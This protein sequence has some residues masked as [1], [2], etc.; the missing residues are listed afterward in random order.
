MAGVLDDDVTP[1]D[2]RLHRE[3]CPVIKGSGGLIRP[4]WCSAD[5]AGLMRAL[6]VDFAAENYTRHPDLL[7]HTEGALQVFFTP[8]DH[9]PR[10]GKVLLV[11]HTP[12]R[13]QAYLALTTTAEQLRAGASIDIALTEASR[14]GSFA[15]AMRRN[16]AAMFDDLGLHQHLGLS[17]CTEL[18]GERRDLLAGTSAICYPV[19]VNDANYGG[20]NPP[21][22]R[23]P[24]LRAF[25]SQVL[26]AELARIP[27]ALIVPL[28]RAAEDGVALAQVDQK[29]VLSGFPHPS[30]ANGHRLKHFEAARERLAATITTWFGAN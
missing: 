28:G 16:I 13:H 26:A 21:I 1:T 10:A 6:P 11:G 25:A 17:S 5:F 27:E 24:I 15:G 19:F 14:V 23:S 4:E 30:G 22:V 29:R 20:G 2:D 3:S 7:L 18:F 9:L 8:F 12:G